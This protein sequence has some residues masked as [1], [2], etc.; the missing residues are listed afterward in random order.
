MRRR[1]EP[2]AYVPAQASAAGGGAWG[3]S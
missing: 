3:R 2:K 1:D